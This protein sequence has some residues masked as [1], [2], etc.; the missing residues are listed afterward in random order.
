MRPRIT[1]EQATAIIE[2]SKTCSYTVILTAL[3]DET[4]LRE[5]AENCDKDFCRS[6]DGCEKPIRA[7]RKAIYERIRYRKGE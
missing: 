1:N 3:E 2:E 5:V 7:Y 4:L 6:F